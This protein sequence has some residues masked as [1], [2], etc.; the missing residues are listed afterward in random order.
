MKEKTV[1]AR[2]RTWYLRLGE[3]HALVLPHVSVTFNAMLSTGSDDDN[4][5]YQLKDSVLRRVERQ[6]P[7]T[8][9]RPCR[10]LQDYSVLARVEA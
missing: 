4:G 2:A 8:R 5:M 7:V 6:A 3:Y 9:A 1:V 10:S